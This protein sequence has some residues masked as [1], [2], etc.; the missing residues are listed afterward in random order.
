MLTTLSFELVEAEQTLRKH[1]H[2]HTYVHVSASQHSL[3]YICKTL[4]L[5]VQDNVFTLA[6]FLYYKIYFKS[7]I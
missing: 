5:K 6:M 2:T 4:P 3:M 1:I 7:Q